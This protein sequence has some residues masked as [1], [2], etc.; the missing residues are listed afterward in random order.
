MSKLVRVRFFGRLGATLGR[1]DWALAVS[2]PTEAL[3]AVEANTGKLVSALLAQWSS[4]FFVVI[5]G[6]VAKS[7]EE[8]TVMR[9]ADL[10][11]I[12]FIPVFRGAG[13]G[14]SGWMILVGVLLVVLVVAFPYIGVGI[15]AHTGVIGGT[16]IGT[17]GAMA[18]TIMLGAGLSL[19][20]A[21]IA[22]MLA[23]SDKFDQNEKPENT[24]SYIFNGAL[25]TYR[26]GNAIPV[27][28]GRLIVG[29]QVISAGVRAVNINVQ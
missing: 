7:I 21:G 25:N 17:A 11:S 14:S 26:Q 23:P 16:T 4:E 20:M 3:Q 15:G 2:S 28:Y 12:D 6:V 9:R 22:G 5:N 10:R 19:V 24:P 13:N 1:Q 27:G 18:G 29:S 8:M